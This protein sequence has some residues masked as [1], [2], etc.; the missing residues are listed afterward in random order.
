MCRVIIAESVECPR[1]WIGSMGAEILSQR[2][3]L[4]KNYSTQETDKAGKP[5]SEVA[6]L[7]EEI[8]TLRQ[9]FETRAARTEKLVSAYKVVLSDMANFQDLWSDYRHTLQFEMTSGV[10]KHPA[11]RFFTEKE[12]AF[13][14]EKNTKP[15]Y[16]IR[17]EKRYEVHELSRLK[18]K[19][20]SV[21]KKEISLMEDLVRLVNL[22]K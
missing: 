12:I 14:G 11:G 7:R 5:D 13:A 16:I 9:D 2:K 18:R 1:D 6:K 22:N 19:V 15:N 20:V 8:S 10:L 21:F 4:E 17:I 3:M